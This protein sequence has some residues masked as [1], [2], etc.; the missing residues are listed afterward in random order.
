M[1]VCRP[2]HVYELCSDCY[3]GLPAIFEK[4]MKRG[5]LCDVQGM[6]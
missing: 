1:L 4:N 3:L 5:Q 2:M 6:R